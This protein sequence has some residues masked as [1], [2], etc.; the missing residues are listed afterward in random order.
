M[1]AS[2]AAV[3]KGFFGLMVRTVLDGTDL[4]TTARKVESQQ[5]QASS[6]QAADVMPLQSAV[7]SALFTANKVRLFEVPDATGNNSE[8]AG[9]HCVQDA[10][11]G[12]MVRR[13]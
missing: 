13:S 7:E 8:C 3:R 2:M 1:A 4:F 9:G 12:E 11:Y 6:M 5:D 10:K